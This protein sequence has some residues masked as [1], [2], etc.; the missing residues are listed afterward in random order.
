[1]LY[2]FD[3]FDTLIT[4]KTQ[5]PKGVFLYMQEELKKIEEYKTIADEFALLRVDAEQKARIFN[6]GDEIGISD[7]YKCFVKYCHLPER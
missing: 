2:S 1:M 5:T 3:V 7:I 6:S 4:R